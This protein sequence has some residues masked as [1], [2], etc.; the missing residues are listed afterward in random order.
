MFKMA[1]ATDPQNKYR[2]PR[3]PHSYET[4]ENLKVTLIQKR[5]QTNM[6]DGYGHRPTKQIQKVQKSKYL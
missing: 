3:N 4:Y 6:Y 2:R 1:V 5:E